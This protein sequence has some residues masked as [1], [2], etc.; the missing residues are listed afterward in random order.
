MHNNIDDTLKA[1][2]NTKMLNVA[3]LSLNKKWPKETLSYCFLSHHPVLS[4]QTL[5]S[6]KWRDGRAA[7]TWTT[8]ALRQPVMYTQK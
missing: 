6:D 3:F 5:V 4:W 7:E 2:Q 8:T 1:K